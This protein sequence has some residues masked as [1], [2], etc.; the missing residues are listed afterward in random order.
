[1]YLLLSLLTIFVSLA[2]A[3]RSPIIY[4]QSAGVPCAYN[5]IA[6]ACVPTSAGSGVDTMAAI[7]GVSNANGASISGTTLTLQPAN[8]SFGGVMT[9]GAQ[10]I[11]GAKILSTSLLVGDTTTDASG[12]KLK[13]GGAA[14]DDYI[15]SFH[16]PSGTGS[17]L[18]F[19]THAAATGVDLQGVTAVTLGAARPINFN[20]SGGVVNLASAG[21]ATNVVG[22]LNVAETLNINGATIASAKMTIRSATNTN[23]LAIIDDNGTTGGG[24][25]FGADGS[26]NGF[27]QGLR[28]DGTANAP[29]AIQNCAQPLQLGN[30]SQVTTMLSNAITLPAYLSCTGFTSNG[31]GLL[32][33]TASDETLKKDIVPFERGLEALAGLTPKTYKFKDP[34]DKNIEHSGFIA[35]N[36]A[37]SIPEAVRISPQG[38]MQ[39]DHLTI[40]AVQANAINELRARLEVLE[41]TKPK[42]LKKAIPMKPLYQIKTGQ[43]SNKK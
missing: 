15:A 2:H 4:G 39:L 6:R 34:G 31:S 33:C 5:L 21:V 42:V 26:N 1:M 27:I 22:T 20:P 17:G 43:S 32:A 38:K 29:V 13:V 14:T 8:A 24:V 16:G 11:A 23:A 25:L 19:V 28:A 35:Q 18:V 30:A 10:T 36:V 12:A 41:G 37:K 40:I 3:A 7:G 9:T